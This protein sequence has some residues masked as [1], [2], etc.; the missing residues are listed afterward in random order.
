MK[1]LANSQQAQFLKEL[2]CVLLGVV[3]SG[4]GGGHG[5]AFVVVVGDAEGP[6]AAAEVAWVFPKGLDRG[7][8]EMAGGAEGQG[9]EVE[10]VEEGPEGADV[11]YGVQE[12]EVGSVLCRVLVRLGCMHIIVEVARWGCRGFGFVNRWGG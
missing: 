10:V 9:A 4:G 7:V 6:A 1:L 3:S 12:G 8:E 5:G 2:D 11:G